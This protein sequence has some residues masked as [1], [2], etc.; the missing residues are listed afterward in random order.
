MTTASDVRVTINID[1]LVNGGDGMGRLE[2][3]E[4]VFVPRSAPGDKVQ[5]E[6][7]REKPKRAEIR[8]ILN[9]SGDRVEQAPP[10]GG[11][12][13]NHLKLSAQREWKQRI[14]AETLSR[15]GKL[16]DVEVSPTLGVPE[17]AARPYR[18]KVRWAVGEKDGGVVLGYY[19]PGTHEVLVLNPCDAMP[20]VFQRLADWL[21]RHLPVETG[22]VNIQARVNHK[23]QVLLT[24]FGDELNIEKL[25]ELVTPMLKAFPVLIGIDAFSGDDQHLLFGQNYLIYELGGKTFRVSS[26]SFFQVNSQAA[27]EMIHWLGEVLPEKTQ[28][29]LD[30]YAG[31]GT[32]AI[33]FADRADKAIAVEESLVAVTDSHINFEENGC[34]NV[35]MKLGD[36]RDVLREYD[37][38]VNVAV[39][40]PPRAGCHPDVLAWVN[41]HVKEQV[42]YVSCDPATLARDLRIL[43]DAGWEIQGVQPLD[44]FPDT[45][46]VE[47]LVNLIRA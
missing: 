26:R 27:A 35:A 6:I 7:V 1:K 34:A 42:I 40:D 45:H 22:I 25:S 29:L 3:G 23:D 15:V 39:L 32:F 43:S 36:A 12:D 24:F 33:C 30:L 44:M 17:S 18:N 37:E 11:C 41:A 46:H 4:V 19:K 2:S 47:T 16:H 10:C 20:E 38:D 31:V 28:T 5:A 9:P 8:Q 13:W 21:Q 14:V